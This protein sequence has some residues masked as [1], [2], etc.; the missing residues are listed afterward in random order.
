[1]YFKPKLEIKLYYRKMYTVMAHI[2][3]FY[4]IKLSLC[5]YKLR[6]RFSHFQNVI[7]FVNV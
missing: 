4:I 6:F 2:V 3:S 7:Q 1:M 5:V